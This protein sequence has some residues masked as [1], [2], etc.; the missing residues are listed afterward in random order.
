MP[1]FF[2]TTTADVVDAGDGVLSLR[3][4]I[5]DANDNDIIVLGAGEYTLTLAD[6]PED[7]NATGDLD[8]VGKSITI[9]GAGT[10]STFIQAGTSDT[11]FDSVDRVF[12]VQ[13]GAG[14]TLENLTVRR[15][16]VI[17]GQSGGGIRNQGEL[18]ITNGAVTGNSASADGGGISMGNNSTLTL[19]NSSILGNVAAANGGGV[20][21]NG[22][23]ARVNIRTSTVANNMAANNGGGVSI[24]RA[25]F[26]LINST[27]S[28]NSAT[29]EGGGI[30]LDN[31]NLSSLLRNIT[32]SG[33][34]ASNGGG[35]RADRVTFGLTNSIIANSP[36]GGDVRVTGGNLFGGG[37]NIV[38]DSPGQITGGQTLGVDPLLG[39]LANNGG[40][41]QTMELLPGSPAIDQSLGSPEPADQRGVGAIG[42]RDLGA[43]EAMPAPMLT[44]LSAQVTY[45]DNVLIAG[46]QRLDTDVSVT[47][48][49]SANFG[50]GLL[51]V[52]YSVGGSAG[53]Q[54]GVENIG[55]GT[56][57]ISV[58]GSTVSYEGTAIAT[59][60]AA[61]NGANGNS[62]GF[63]LN[64]NATLAATEALIE[65]LTYGN[66]DPA[67]SPNSR[68][69]NITINDGFSDST[70]Q[71]IEVIISNSAAPVL[72]DLAA[73]VTYTDN[74]LATGAQRLD[75]DVSVTDID[76]TNFDGGS[77]TVSYG[78]GGSAEDQLGVEN[79]GTGAGQ[80]SISGT[81]VSFGETAIAT[82]TSSGTNG[83]N[84]SF[85]LN[86]AATPVA[87]EALIESLTYGN[88]NLGNPTASRALNITLNDGLNTSTA[89]PITVVVNNTLPDI[90]VFGGSV[91]F[92]GQT[93]PFALDSAA[94]GQTFERSLRVSNRGDDVLNLAGVSVPEGFALTRLDDTE[95][96]S[97]P[98][99]DVLEPGQALDL[100]LRRTDLQVTSFTGDLSFTSNDPDRPNFVIPL[101]GTIT[102]E[103]QAPLEI[104]FTLT[105]LTLP[106]VEFSPGSL[107]LDPGEI[108][109]SPGDG[110]ET[111]IGS[112]GLDASFGF[113][114][115]DNLA[116]GGGRDLLNGNGGDDQ[117][118]G[119]PGNDRI[120]GGSGNDRILAG[121]GDDIVRGNSGDDQIDGGDDNDILLGDS[122]SDFIDGGAGD[123]FIRGGT[124][125]DSIGGGLGNDFILGE[126]GDDLLAGE[127]GN[128]QLFGGD[129]GD[130][131]DGGLDNDL[132]NGGAGND[133][134]FGN[135]GNDSLV[136]EDGA[137]LLEGGV[138]LDT[139]TGGLG[140]DTF[141]VDI[142]SVVA[143]TS[144]FDVITDFED[145]TD[146]I[147][148][149]G[150][151]TVDTLTWRDGANGLEV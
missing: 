65:S 103:A 40:P 86:S 47:D 82:I 147:A 17:A 145:G 75:T 28:N 146:L 123:D 128:D 104:N 143:G 148:I 12:D 142:D 96:S 126:A 60:D 117:I 122:G 14:L 92:D 38:E 9:Q 81:T 45:A 68:T 98:L 18:V 114:G 111:V 85:T 136:G 127:D 51:T 6:S 56:G 3:E 137:D 50:G 36:N 1:T 134:L 113:G 101:T 20:Q 57:E 150:L 120:F 2:V 95:I 108:V 61:N 141:A 135:D 99:S 78:T 119:G 84:L 94:F 76:S 39:P 83:T 130:R 22:N 73:Q 15:G 93:T 140:A 71:P 107:Q 25:R 23:A 54:L 29:N 33:N 110:S 105:R 138:G 77:L 31:P 52:S 5:N 133:V 106:P 59:I 44:G 118:D 26:E 129:G 151:G 62:L 100:T 144:E 70:P 121:S 63:S 116:G 72:T 64:A 79:I 8:I 131:L 53:D 19:T 109:L 10:G 16:K 89:Q 46:V 97:G 13:G 43:F 34:G 124:D 112:D 87:V 27:I 69:L 139:L 125:P 4:A 102:F 132:L 41:T 30:H 58:S 24:S 91:N 149:A 48:A 49:D 21:G 37:R 88:T 7:G 42:I 90:S 67:N 66:T 115:N 35:I 80:I 32:V 74:V 55:T 11:L